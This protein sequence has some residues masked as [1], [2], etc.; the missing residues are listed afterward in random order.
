M[1]FKGNGSIWMDFKGNGCIGNGVFVLGQESLVLFEIVCQ[2]D[3]SMI[4]SEVISSML[5]AE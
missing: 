4:L 1:E 5:L 2:L 3:L